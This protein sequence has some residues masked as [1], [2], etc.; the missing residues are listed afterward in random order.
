MTALAAIR[1]DG[2]NVPLLFHV[3]GAMVLVGG[4][5]TAVVFQALASA[6]T[7]FWALLFVA[8]P[9]WV[10]MRIGGQ[11][12]YSKEGWSGED[13]PAWLGIGFLTADLGGVLLLLTVV[14]AGLGV[15]RAGAWTSVLGRLAAGL[16]MVL[17]IA[18]LV[19]AWAMSAKP[20]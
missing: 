19:A 11:W 1:P 2:W 6:R 9:A 8:V 20:T 18:Y 14:L 13:D 7:A 12:I 5:V 15:R 16:A 4:L 3:L 10:L 17:L